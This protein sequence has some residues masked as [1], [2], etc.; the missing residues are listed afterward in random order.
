M[1]KFIKEMFSLIPED[2]VNTKSFIDQLC[3]AIE[4]AEKTRRS[5]LRSNLPEKNKLQR[6]QRLKRQ[7]KRSKK[8]IKI[9]KLLNNLT[10]HR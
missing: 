2:E 8:R 6:Q 5:I 7:A 4:R 10:C 9:P 1:W 3:E